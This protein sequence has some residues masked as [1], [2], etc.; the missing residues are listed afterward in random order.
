MKIVFFAL[1][2]VFSAVTCVFTKEVAENI[3]SSRIIRSAPYSLKVNDS[4]VVIGFTENKDKLSVILSDHDG[5]VIFS[6]DTV[7]LDH[8]NSVS[9]PLTDTSKP[10]TLNIRCASFTGKSFIPGSSK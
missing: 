6:N 5:N 10:M 3:D 9:I 4:V 7:M 1:Y 8:M 2:F